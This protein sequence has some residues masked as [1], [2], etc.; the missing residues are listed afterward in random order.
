LNGHDF[1]EITLN[2][3]KVSLELELRASKQA[4]RAQRRS[5]PMCWY[6]RA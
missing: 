6:V 2:R 4:V 5:W 1:S 3:S